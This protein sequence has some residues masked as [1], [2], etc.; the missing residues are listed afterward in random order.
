MLPETRRVAMHALIAGVIITG[1]KFGVFAITNSV[2][3]LSDALE[4][5]INIAAAAMMLYTMWLSSRPADPSHP[6]GHGK[7][8]VLAVGLEGWMILFSGLLILYEAVKRL[9][10]GND[11]VDARIVY[12]MWFLGGIGVLSAALAFYVYRAGKHYNN[13]TLIADGKHLFTDV[14][15]T[16]AVFLGLALVEWTGWTRLDPIVAIVISAFILWVSWR[17][18]WQSV[19][20]IMDNTDPEDDATIR[21]ILDD[22]L[23][24]GA[25][26][27][28]H[29][30]RY[31]HTGKFHWVDMHLQV[32]GG[33][34]VAQSHALASRI[35][36]RIERALGEANATAHVEPFDEPSEPYAAP[37]PSPPPPPSAPPPPAGEVEGD[38]ST[39]ELK[40]PM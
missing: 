23:A 30:V 19:E 26:K 15:S 5:L 4:S 17:L 6:Y 1:L 20:G 9:I 25:I 40:E 18:L 16:T 31:R 10:F 7:A 35:E 27:G 34:S 36:G 39:Y 13:P 29:K 24:Q 2:A 28:Y 8:E 12:G 33:L 32:D 38:A 3:V 21:R 11:L 14:A 37:P 22:E